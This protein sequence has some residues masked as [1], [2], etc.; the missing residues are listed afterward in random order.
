MKRV[1]LVDWL[2]GVQL[3]FRQMHRN[4]ASFLEPEIAVQDI[5][6]CE[7]G[8]VISIGICWLPENKS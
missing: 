7:E 1:K 4:S 8:Y 2:Q 6:F 3:L 5:V